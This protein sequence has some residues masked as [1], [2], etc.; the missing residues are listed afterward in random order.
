MQ[1]GL[2]PNLRTTFAAWR[3][4]RSFLAA[5]ICARLRTSAAKELCS[6]LVKL[7]VSNLQISSDLKTFLLDFLSFVPVEIRQRQ[8]ADDDIRDTVD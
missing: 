3:N 6:C 1:F 8:T 5:R 2:D 4:P 7:E